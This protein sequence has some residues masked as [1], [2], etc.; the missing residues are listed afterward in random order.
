MTAA[1][2]VQTDSARSRDRILESA[3][4]LFWRQGF[5]GTSLAQVAEGARVS[6]SLICWHFQS[7]ADLFRAALERAL[8]AVAFDVRGDL[9]GLSEVD[10]LNWLIDEYYAF[11]STHFPSVKF[12]LGLVVG[13]EQCREE[14]VRRVT[15]A[16]L[17]YRNLMAAV[18]EAAQQK[19]LVTVHVQAGP[20]A[21]LIMAALHGIL[22]GRSSTA[23]LPSG[24]PHCFATSRFNLS[25]RC[26]AGDGKRPRGLKG[27]RK[28]DGVRGR[29]SGA[30]VAGRR[31]RESLLLAAYVIARC[32][33]AKG[34]F[35]W[36]SSVPALSGD[37][38]GTAASRAGERPVT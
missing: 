34:A 1:E 10:Q 8:D 15:H 9:Q 19:G 11:V 17:G 32:C 20:H 4:G 37:P 30:G 23:T 38:R 25:S 13:I 24:R 7:K 2:L 12:L 27:S 36:S 22:S 33:Y 6:K 29:R 14:V 5:S 31:T 26:A 3:T 28:H 18:L 35:C 16:Q 21:S